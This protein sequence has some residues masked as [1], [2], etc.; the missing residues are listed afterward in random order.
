MLLVPVSIAA[1]ALLP[2]DMDF[3]CTVNAE[4]RDM[5]MDIRQIEEN[6]HVKGMYQYE[7]SLGM[8]IYSIEPV[9]KLLFV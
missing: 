6:A 4:R 9:Y 1:N 5:R 8:L 7:G 3:P 2:S